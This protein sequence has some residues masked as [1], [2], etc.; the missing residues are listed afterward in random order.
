MAQAAHLTLDGLAVRDRHSSTG[1]A[2]YA[3]GNL[4]LRRCE[5]VNN[6]GGGIGSFAALVIEDSLVH[7]NRYLGEGG[8]CPG[9]AGGITF[10]GVS[11]RL[12]NTTFRANS[13]KH[14]PGYAYGGALAVSGGYV[15]IES[16]R[17]EANEA[18]YGGALL[19]QSTNHIHVLHTTL[20]N[21]CATHQGGG[22][23]VYNIRMRMS[24]VT[25]HGGRAGHDSGA[26]AVVQ[27][28]TILLEAC[29]FLSNMAPQGGA[30]T[31]GPTSSIGMSSTTFSGNMAHATVALDS[32]GVHRELGGGGAIMNR[33]NATIDECSFRN[34][35]AAESFGGGVANLRGATL[36]VRGSTF[37]DNMADDGGA[38]AS[39]GIARLL[40]CT[41][42]RNLGNHGGAIDNYKAPSLEVHSCTFNL[43]KAH[44]AGG[45]LHNAAANATIFDCHI[46]GNQAVFGG[47]IIS[48]AYADAGVSCGGS[49]R[50]ASASLHVENSSIV[51]NRAAEG[52]GL[53]NTA[54][55][56]LSATQL[57]NNR[58]TTDLNNM[59]FH[60]HGAGP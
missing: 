28:S 41:L 26:F 22:S 13:H 3:D 49:S 42:T 35:S 45:A 47:G 12:F 23:I 54:A 1:P 16:C 9:C 15:W 58:G 10:Q 40:D 27:D 44:W 59:T 31:I 60:F 39:S 5:I 43:N 17:F 57:H 33:G 18:D 14:N 38:L 21:N 50:D 8:T 7:E 29:Q 25:F 36:V 2:I 30:L 52:A 24:N 48:H 53:Y 46:E 34:N 6:T 37:V 32:R 4:T 56:W 11:L 19:F 55:F 51:A 20:N